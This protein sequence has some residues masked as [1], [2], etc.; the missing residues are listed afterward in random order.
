LALKYLRIAVTALSVVACL[1]LIGLWVRSYW[2]LDKAF[3]PSVDLGLA[4]LYGT[5]QLHEMDDVDEAVMLWHG[6][7]HSISLDVMKRDGPVPNILDTIVLFR[8]EDRL[9]VVPYWFLALIAAVLGVVPWP[10]QTYRRFSLRTLLIAT[11]LVAVVLG[12]IAVSN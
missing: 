8:F 6:Q 3:V 2:W 4:S 12:A 7:I 5:V 10:K 11:T 1:L 9:F